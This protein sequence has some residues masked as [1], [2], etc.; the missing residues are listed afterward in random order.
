MKKIFLFIC[1]CVCLCTCVKAQTVSYTY[2]PFSAEGCQMKYSVAKQDTS[3]FIIATVSSDRMRFLNEPTMKI[4]TF[5][6]E[7]IT[8]SGV[9]I[10]DGSNSAGIMSGNIMIPISEI[11]S[12]AQF[13]VTPAQFEV[14]KNG[15]S[16]LRLSMAPMNHERT[17]KKDKIGNKLYEFYLKVNSQDDNF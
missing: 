15:I 2:K 6:D 1:L 4:R 12:T 5:N 17:F 3:F 16:K 11:N 14:I 9:I 10:G 7:V 8:L 13:R